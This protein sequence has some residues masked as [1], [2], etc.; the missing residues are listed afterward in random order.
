MPSARHARAMRVA[1][2]PRLATS[3]R[4]N[5]ERQ[6][7]RRRPVFERSD[8]PLQCP[9]MNAVSSCAALA[10]VLGLARTR[11]GIGEELARLS[12]ARVQEREAA[13]RWLAARLAPEDYPELAKA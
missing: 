2:S 12:S 4:A 1:T 10:V 8:G 13:E 5:M 11:D 9:S 3:K 6:G 7:T